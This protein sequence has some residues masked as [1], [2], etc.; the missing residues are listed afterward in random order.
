MAEHGGGLDEQGRTQI[1][2]PT[3]TIG[4]SAALALNSHA[5][6]DGWIKMKGS[7]MSQKRKNERKSRVVAP[8]PAGMWFGSRA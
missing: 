2:V 7:C 1:N 4:T 3:Q 6:L 8:C 5:S